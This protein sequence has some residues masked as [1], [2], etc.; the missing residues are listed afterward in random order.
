MGVWSCMLSRKPQ[1]AQRQ[2]AKKNREE[3]RRVMEEHEEVG[4][5]VF[6]HNYTFPLTARVATLLSTFLTTFLTT[7]FN[8]A[9]ITIPK[10]KNF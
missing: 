9:T 6:Y 4:S 7:F 8:N 3:L 5:S 1:E 10:N 2:Q